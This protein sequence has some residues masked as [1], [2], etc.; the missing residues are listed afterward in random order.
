MTDETR[1]TAFS[2]FLGSLTIGRVILGLTLAAG[3]VLL[4][5]LWEAR[6]AWVDTM[7]ASPALLALIGAG[8]LLI[9]M[10]AGFQ[11]RLEASQTL[12]YRQMR[13]TADG[14]QHR[15]DDAIRDR[16]SF[17]QQ[18]TSC[19]QRDAAQQSRLVRLEVQVKMLKGTK[20]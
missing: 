1:I 9:A 17:Q 6:L 12:M 8:V 4:W 15:I 7:F 10:G 13:D 16:N 5:A 11:A 19:L 3:S 20:S 2:N 14:L 18:L